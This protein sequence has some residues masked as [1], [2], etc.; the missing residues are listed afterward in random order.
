MEKGAGPRVMETE[1]LFWNVIFY[2][3]EREHWWDWLTHPD[4]RHV[5]IYGW[6]SDRWVSFD[7]ADTRSRIR[8]MT[9]DE[10][11]IWLLEQKETATAIVK[12]PTQKGGGIP[13]RMGLWCVNGVKHVLGL[14]SSALRPRALFRDLMANDAEVIFTNGNESERSFR[15]CRAEGGA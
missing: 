10:F 5:S 3:N 1:I 6:M 2:R 9:Q 7:V 4:W 15:E 13:A 11:V 8:V 14:R 12:I